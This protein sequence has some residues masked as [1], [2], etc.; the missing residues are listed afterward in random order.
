MYSPQD[1]IYNTP[2]I[3]APAARVILQQVQLE[4]VLQRFAISTCAKHISDRVSPPL[5]STEQQRKLTKFDDWYNRPSPQNDVAKHPYEVHCYDHAYVKKRP[6][7][8]GIPGAPI[9]D[10]YAQKLTNTVGGGKY[11]AVNLTN[12]Y[13]Q[14]AVHGPSLFKPFYPQK[15]P[16]RLPALQ[17]QTSTGNA[18]KTLQDEA[19]VRHLDLHKRDE[20][21]KLHAERRPMKR[22]AKKRKNVIKENEFI[23]WEH[24]QDDYFARTPKMTTPGMEMPQSA[25]H[26]LEMTEMADAYRY[27]QHISDSIRRSV[28]HSN[29]ATVVVK[30]NSRNRL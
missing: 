30:F 14:K 7:R 21:G 24:N 29:V 15:C 16:L 27:R 2:D 5:V 4:R 20:N 22:P 12:N 13:T 19:L 23:D 3:S 9:N 11:G 26:E 10:P 6:I 17:R 1:R 18:N 8:S 25:L 28:Q